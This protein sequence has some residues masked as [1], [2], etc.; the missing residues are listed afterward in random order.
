MKKRI[1]IL[2]LLILFVAYPVFADYIILVNSKNKQNNL[3]K[4]ELRTIFLLDMPFW[5]NGDSVVPVFVDIDDKISYQFI[6][7]YLNINLM[8]FKKNVK[9][10]L[11]NQDFFMVSDI[12]NAILTVSENKGAITY[13]PDSFTPPILFNKSTRQ[14]K[15][16]E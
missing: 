8:T 5:D 14:M 12:D 16:I 13:M 4:F 7:S 10:K 15:I 3:Y 1:S 6:S 11:I 2:L 9:S